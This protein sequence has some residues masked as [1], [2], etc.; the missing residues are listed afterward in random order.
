MIQSWYWDHR[1]SWGLGDDV[2]RAEATVDIDINNWKSAV[3]PLPTAPHTHWF[4][5]GPLHIYLWEICQDTLIWWAYTLSCTIIIFHSIEILPHL[6]SHSV[7]TICL[8]HKTCLWRRVL[9]EKYHEVS[10]WNGTLAKV[11]FEDL[12][13]FSNIAV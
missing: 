1:A 10:L 13:Q 5:S 6:P 12:Q 11:T 9:L 8:K 7:S 4:R 2:I 3:A